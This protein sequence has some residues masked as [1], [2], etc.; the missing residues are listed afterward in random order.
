MF[1]VIL[2]ATFLVFLLITSAHF[3]HRGVG[4]MRRIETNGHHFF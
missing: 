1:G 4:D 2:S 3:L